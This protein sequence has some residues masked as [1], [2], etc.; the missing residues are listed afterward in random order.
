MQCTDF[1]SEE[2]SDTLPI[3]IAIDRKQQQQQQQHLTTNSSE[4][5]HTVKE[6]PAHSASGGPLPSSSQPLER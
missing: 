5:P 3:F 1:S 6:G 2:A 4:L